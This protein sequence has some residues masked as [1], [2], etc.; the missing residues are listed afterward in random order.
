M[1]GDQVT[2]ATLRQVAGE[3]LGPPRVLAELCCFI[4]TQPPTF[5]A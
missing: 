4:A 5:L 2:V 3:N 1:I